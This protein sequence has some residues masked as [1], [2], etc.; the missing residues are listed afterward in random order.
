MS[1]GA[2][3]FGPIEGWRGE[4]LSFVRF[5]ADGRVARY[6]PRDPSWFTWPAVERLIHGNIVP[7]F[8]VCNKSVN[9]WYS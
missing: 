2:A 9:A 1:P 5:D 6:F 7:G 8:P 4:V 3:C